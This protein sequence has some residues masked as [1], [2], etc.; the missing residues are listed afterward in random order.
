MR[1]SMRVRLG[2]NPLRTHLMPHS[3]VWMLICR[4]SIT[5][6]CSNVGGWFRQ[7]VEISFT[8]PR[9][10]ESLL[11]SK[12]LDVSSVLS[13]AVIHLHLYLYAFTWTKCALELGR[14]TAT[15]RAITSGTDPRSD[16]MSMQISEFSPP[17][18]HVA[19]ARPRCRKTFITGYGSKRP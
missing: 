6:T 10:V 3:Y 4:F 18:C 12:L 16:E 19:L 14:W 7:E 11:T 1:I 5:L 2:S 8:G 13:H 9:Q 17:F 15:V